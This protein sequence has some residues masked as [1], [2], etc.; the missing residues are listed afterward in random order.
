MQVNIVTLAG[1]ENLADVEAFV[2]EL[3]PPQSILDG[4][5]AWEECRKKNFDWLERVQ[6]ARVS[7]GDTSKGNEK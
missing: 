7:L 4:I 6:A 3:L 1:C 5:A 2:R